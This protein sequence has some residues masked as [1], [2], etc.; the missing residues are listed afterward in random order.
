VHVPP[1]TF[2]SWY[3]R[4]HNC[5]YVVDA[6]EILSLKS[7]IENLVED[8]SLRQI[9]VANARERARVDFDPIVSSQAF[10]QAMQAAL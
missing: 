9:L 7:A 1:D 2:I 3:F 4:K 6:N 8:S 10:L 5:G